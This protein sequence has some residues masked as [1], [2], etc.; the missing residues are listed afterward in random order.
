MSNSKPIRKWADGSSRFVP[1][2][3]PNVPNSKW[4]NLWQNFVDTQSFPDLVLTVNGSA[5]KV[6]KET[7]LAFHKDL[8]RLE[9]GEVASQMENWASEKLEISED[10]EV[11]K[12]P[13]AKDQ[14]QVELERRIL[15]NNATLQKARNTMREAVES[16]KREWKVQTIS[17]LSELPN[18]RPAL[19]AY[20][21]GQPRSERVVENFKVP[22]KGE[23]QEW[24]ASW[25]RNNEN[26]DN[27]D[28]DGFWA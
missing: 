5:F 24:S 19:S 2:F 23:L 10:L 8:S 12:E 21:V 22:T 3:E 1:K 28:V 4:K 14:L 15:C 26:S 7:F 13:T 17:C 25:G 6:G 16:R 20:S 9:A 11:A 27:M 18:S